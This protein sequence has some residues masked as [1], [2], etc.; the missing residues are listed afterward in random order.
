MDLVGEIALSGRQ[1]NGTAS[2]KTNQEEE[3]R[4]TGR[5]LRGRTR[6]ICVGMEENGTASR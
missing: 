3:D 4:R 5:S 1:I 6:L 2:E